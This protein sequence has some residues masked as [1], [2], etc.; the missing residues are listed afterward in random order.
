MTPRPFAL[1]L[2]ALCWRAPPAYAD[3]PAQVA[4][5][6]GHSLAAPG[7]KSASGETE[8]SFNLRQA[9]W[10]QQ[11]LTHDGIGTR[12]IGAAGDMVRLTDRTAQASQAKLF[13][14]V[15][16]D[17]VQ[18]QYLPEADRFH[19][20]SVFVSRKNPYPDQS[21]ACAR[22]V[23]QALQ[24]AG[25]RPTLHHAEPIP[26]ENRPLADAALGVYWFDDLV[27]LKTARQPALLVEHGVIVNAREEARLKR[28]EVEKKLA[29]AVADG[30]RQCLP[31]IQ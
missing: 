9:Q 24:A 10:L 19:G 6:V 13:V 23:A 20:Y 29:R 25:E 22:H 3:A 27:V 31:L 12:L 8:F 14:S 4:I 30:L 21:L 5:D 16:H 15:H 18:P 1:L 7:A 2:F 28:P 17:S 11:A 26:G